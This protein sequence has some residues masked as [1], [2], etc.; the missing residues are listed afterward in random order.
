M[1]MTTKKRKMMKMTKMMMTRK[2]GEEREEKP[3]QDSQKWSELR[4]SSRTCTS[5]AQRAWAGLQERKKRRRTMTKT[6]K[7]TRMKL[8]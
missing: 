4:H 2:K 8:W 7:K 3:S 5:W 1:T 6:T